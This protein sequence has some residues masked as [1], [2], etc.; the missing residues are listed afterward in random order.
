M[1][2]TQSF[3]MQSQADA[4]DEIIVNEQ[5][6][7]KEVN[8]QEETFD[9]TNKEKGYSE[10]QMNNSDQDGEKPVKKEKTIADLPG[11]E[12]DPGKEDSPEPEKAV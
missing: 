7:D 11:T 12:T 2:Q 5:E 6:Q 10:G 3:K 9:G 8:S 1:N 4:P